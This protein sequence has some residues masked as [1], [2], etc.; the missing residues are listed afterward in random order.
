MLAKLEQAKGVFLGDHRKRRNGDRP[1]S[2]PGEKGSRS[3]WLRAKAAQ[4]MEAAKRCVHN[5]WQTVIMAPIRAMV[6]PLLHVRTSVLARWKRA[7]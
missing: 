6:R 7:P 5:A 2:V 3:P 4:G 1:A